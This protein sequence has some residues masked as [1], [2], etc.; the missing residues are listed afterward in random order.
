MVRYF[1]EAAEHSGLPQ[2]SPWTATRSWTSILPV[3]WFLAPHTDHFHLA[4]HLQSSIP[5][6]NI[7]KAH[8]L[9]MTIVEYAAGH[10]CDG[11]FFAHRPDAPSVVQDMR[12]PERRDPVAQA[13]GDLLGALGLQNDGPDIVVTGR[14][15][16]SLLDDPAVEAAFLDSMAGRRMASRKEDR[17]A[18]R[19]RTAAEERNDA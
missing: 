9:L 2:D 3:R 1:G 19:G 6:F 16:L 15:D 5:H 12:H 13:P 17:T 8:A 18:H 4:H 7:A 10:H 14:G 11:F